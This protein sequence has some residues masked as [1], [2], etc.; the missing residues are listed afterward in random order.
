MRFTNKNAHSYDENHHDA[1]TRDVEKAI[2]G[3]PKHQR[4][5]FAQQWHADLVDA[6]TPGERTSVGKA[7]LSMSR[8]LRFRDF[9]L[10]FIGEHGYRRA[11]LLWLG[12][13]ALLA[14]T[15][16]L[17]GIY[18]LI[19]LLALCIALIYVGAPSVASYSLMVVSVVC[20]AISFVYF[21]IAFRAGFNAADAS[22]PAPAWSTWDGEAL[23]VFVICVCGFIASIFWSLKRAR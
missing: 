4:E 18:I 11:A 5:R 15:Q 19:L 16:V 1:A 22:Q 8:R 14:L 9:G 2:R 21:V 6:N 17:P 23:I 13:I 20:G 10:S 12:I 3:L 7:A